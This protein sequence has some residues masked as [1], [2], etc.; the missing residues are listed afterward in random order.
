MRHTIDTQPRPAPGTLAP[1]TPFICR[2]IPHVFST[3]P[4][5]KACPPPLFS[6]ENLRRGVQPSARGNIYV[7]CIYTHRG[8]QALEFTIMQTSP[9]SIDLRV[10]YNID[11]QHSGTQAFEYI[12]IQNSLYSIVLRVFNNIDLQQSGT[13]AFEY[14]IIQTFSIG[15]SGL[16]VFND[17]DLLH[18]G[19]RPQ[20]SQ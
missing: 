8:T 6:I 3:P 16:K 2:E 7:Y 12:I 15:K 13:Q 20:S 1:S 17:I 19:I 14:L 18:W 9:Y 5:S 11:L 10:F 4:L